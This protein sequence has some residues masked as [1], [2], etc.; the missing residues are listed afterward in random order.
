[1]LVV[2]RLCAEGASRAGLKLALLD[3]RTRLVK[4]IWRIIDEGG[5][6]LVLRVCVCVCESPSVPKSFFMLFLNFLMVNFLQA[7]DRSTV[8]SLL[9]TKTLVIRW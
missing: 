8:T 1:M 2:L 3:A 4:E 6:W 5:L 7:G 9:S